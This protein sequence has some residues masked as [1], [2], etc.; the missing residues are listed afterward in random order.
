MSK[1]QKRLADRQAKPLT[2][3]LLGV[4]AWVIVLIFFFPVLWMVLTGLKTETDA[5][6]STPHFIFSRRSPSTNR[7]GRGRAA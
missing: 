7:S 2:R 4:L 6:T 3:L 1:Q 5:N